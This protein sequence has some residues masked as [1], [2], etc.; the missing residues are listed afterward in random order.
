MFTVHYAP[1]VSY[2]T[3]KEKKYNIS[4]LFSP[5]IVSRLHSSIEKQLFS[6]HNF[7][8]INIILN[9]AVSL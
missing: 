1:S 9:I 5:N 3:K 7:R 2:R 4:P 6:I 8:S